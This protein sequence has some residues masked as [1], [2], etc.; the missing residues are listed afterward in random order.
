MDPFEQRLKR[1]PL[2]Q[3]PADWREEILTMAREAQPLRQTATVQGDSLFSVLNRRLASLLWPHP[4][5]WGGLAAVWVLIFAAHFSIE[6]KAPVM[7]EKALPPS[8]EVVAELRQQQRMLA[9]LIGVSD[10]SDADRP[11]VLVPA[12]RSERVV[13]LNA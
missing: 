11:K 4:V 10:A 3:A 7:A 1:Q 9:E 13:I 2:R 6:D 12:P 5:A 8:P